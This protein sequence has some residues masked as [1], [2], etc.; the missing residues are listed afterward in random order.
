MHWAQYNTIKACVSTDQLAGVYVLD[1]KIIINTPPE[2]IK[3]ASKYSEILGHMAYR[4]GEDFYLYRTD[5]PSVLKGGLMV[6]GCATSIESGNPELLSEEIVRECDLRDFDGV[7]LSVNKISPLLR[8][9]ISLL[10]KKLGEKMLYLPEE[11][12]EASETARVIISTA[13]SGGSLATRLQEVNAAYGKERLCL[14]IERVRMDF[15]LPSRDGSGRAISA[16]EL[17]TLKKTY[18]SQPYFSQELCAYYFTFNDKHGS[19]FIL[20]DDVGSIRK[21]LQLA[22]R[23]GIPA[24]LLLYPEVEDIIGL[25]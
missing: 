19:H 25:L 2:N 24:A 6:L 17:Q 20:Y 11:C 1:T 3:A 22:I 23:L 16:G 18:H 15:R 14:D 4:I 12:A 10:S 9:L 13:I 8:T 21:K 5:I 7:I